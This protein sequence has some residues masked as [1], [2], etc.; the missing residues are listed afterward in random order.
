[1]KSIKNKLILIISILVSITV[2]AVA[3]LGYTF[4]SKA[5]RNAVSKN[6][7]DK[8]NADIFSMFRYIQ[9]EHGTISV[10]DDG[11]LIDSHGENLE[12]SNKVVDMVYQ[13]LDAAA[14]IY[15]KEG[16]DFKIVTTNVR[17]KNSER[18]IGE[19]LDKKSSAYKNLSKGKAYVG[20]TNINGEDYKTSYLLIYSD[21][22]KVVGA[23]SI[24][25]P[26]SD[27]KLEIRNSLNS[28]A[29]IFIVIIVVSLIVNIVFASLI[30]IAITKGLVKVSEFSDNLRQLDIKDN[31]P[32]NVLALRDEVGDV[33]NS[34][35]VAINA[36]RDFVSDTDSISDNVKEYTE[37]VLKN[38][39]QVR[40]SASEISL[41]ANQIAEGATSQ[42]KETESGNI[43]AEELGES[44]DSNK[45]D[46][47]LLVN[48]MKEV[49]TLRAEGINIVKELANES[50]KAI[51]A[52]NE[53]YN[54]IEETNIKAKDIE[55][56]SEIIKDISE[57]INLVALNASI[58]AARAGESGKGFSVVAEEVRKLAEESNK[59]NDEI[60]NVVKELTVKTESA[61]ETVNKMVDMMKK[62]HNSVNVT[63]NKFEGISNSLKKTNNALD[64]LNKSSSDIEEKKDTM[65]NLMQNLSAIAEENAASTQEVSASVEEQTSIISS[66]SHSINEMAEMSDKMKENISKF[67]Y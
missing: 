60:E 3:I 39:N 21:N 5:I 19:V 53:I 20:I 65:I 48:L 1:M 31:I 28:L 9:Q 41:A 25:V 37:E 32:D 61:V 24:G 34:M 4:S 62:Q 63:V 67:Q 56:A 43:E 23:A 42:A 36:L 27:I 66:L 45:K 16:N 57:Q 50:V 12:K 58:E 6:I 51:E 30:G 55:K 40:T 26:I 13:D 17:D 18:V 46:L 2:S 8:L 29:I 49:E 33:A 52:T 44:I 38:M 15:K 14:T 10:N 22:G 35:Q 7:E 47:A 54:V 59:S 64:N 11:T